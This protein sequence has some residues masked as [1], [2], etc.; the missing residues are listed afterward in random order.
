MEEAELDSTLWQQL[1]RDVL[2]KVLA[3]LPVSSL[4]SFC[5]VCKRWKTLIRS[6]EF[7]RRYLSVKPVI[8]RHHPRYQ[9]LGPSRK[10]EKPYLEIPCAKTNVWKKHTLDFASEDVD[11]VAA[12]EGLICFK[13]SKS[14]SILFIYNPLTRHVRTLR[15]PEYSERSCWVYEEM[16]VGLTVDPDTGN[17]RLLV[18][19][20]EMYLEEDEET[21]GTHI[22]DSLY[23]TWTSTSLSPKLPY[24][25]HPYDGDVY[26][27]DMFTKWA[28][29]ASVRSGGN[30]YWVVEEITDSS[31]PR[32]FRFLVK[33][34]IQES[35]WIVDEPFLPYVTVEEE[36][37][38]RHYLSYSHLVKKPGP[39]LR[40]DFKVPQRNFNLA[41]HDGTV[42]ATLFDSLIRRNSFS[43]LIPEVQL[44]DEGFVRRLWEAADAPEQYFPTTMIVA[45][46][47]TWF[48]AF[49]ADGVGC[50]E[51]G[52]KS[53]RVFVHSQSRNVSRWLP[54]MRLDTA[55]CL[56]PELHSFGATFRAMV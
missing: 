39:L 41:T 7:A 21:R 27:W 52:M 46:G 16:L 37:L 19:F 25:D 3:K 45:Q 28:P 51:R 50:E 36:N 23:S 15:V 6:N 2:E 38:Y 31:R 24:P 12:D 11:L 26:D 54:D 35:A 49:E 8:F 44:L 40:W 20:I 55:R 14:R 32:H 47:D 43:D 30:F 10:E 48:V 9:K 18:G 5:R 13:R 1:P 33:Y 34:D 22:Y 56:L 42:F 29:K 53:L 4:M 17:Y